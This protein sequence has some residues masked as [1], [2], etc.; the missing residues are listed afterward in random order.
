MKTF[1]TEVFGFAIKHSNDQLIEIDTNSHT[2]YA[3]NETQFVGLVMELLVDNLDDAK[4]YF[5]ANGCK[6][7]KWEGKG[8]DC[9]IEDPFGI[10]YNVWETASHKKEEQL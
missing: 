6:I 7:L 5:Q 9:Y 3:M 8:R 10:R 2:I 1:Y 4:E